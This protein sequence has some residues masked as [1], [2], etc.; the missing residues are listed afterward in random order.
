MK[1]ISLL[2]ISIITLLIST[3]VF[4]LTSEQLQALK[5]IEQKVDSSPQ[6]LGTFSQT[7]ILPQLPRPLVSNGILAVSE[8]IGLS[9][10][11]NSPIESHRIFK[12]AS[13][14]ND[15]QSPNDIIESH[16]ADPLIQI[17]NGDFSKLSQSFILNPKIE[18]EYW[19]IKLVPK[20][21]SFRNIIQSIEVTGD[22]KIR[23]I[24]LAEA[25]KAITEIKIENFHSVEPN[26][27]QLLS[28]FS[29]D[30]QK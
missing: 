6:M 21:E 4:A 13:S 2:F 19:Q 9:W 25:S 11:I 16:V 8:N 3:V 22:E 24:T 5:E 30:N 7:K 27:G 12:I 10:R 1:S 18:D 26:N 20:Q 23:R 28:E 15:S 29:E 17:V 14:E